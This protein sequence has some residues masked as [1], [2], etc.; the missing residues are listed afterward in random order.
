MTTRTKARGI[1]RCLRGFSLLEL[2]LVLAIMGIL[3]AVAAVAIGGQGTRAKKK[4]TEA[5][6]TVLKGQLQAY[7]LEHSSYPPDLRTL[8]TA[9][10]IEDG[11]LRDG[12]NRDLI[13]DP[14]G[15]DAD[16][17][18]VLGS[19]GENGT[20]GDADDID[21]WTMNKPAAN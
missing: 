4:A 1:R 11:S 13:F 8:I 21:V 10:F 14:R 20:P 2:T 15:R 9:K 19:A 16:H 17:P 3:I 5:T 6:L 12:W 18:F 7:H